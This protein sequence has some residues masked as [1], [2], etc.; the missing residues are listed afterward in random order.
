MMDRPL[1]QASAIVLRGR[2]AMRVTVNGGN[3][4]ERTATCPF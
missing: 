2:Q 1:R 3:L 4:F